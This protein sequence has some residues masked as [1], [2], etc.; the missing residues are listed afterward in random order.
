[1]IKEN[2][3]KLEKLLKKVSNALELEICSLK[4]QT[5]HNP[6]VLEIIIKKTSGDDISLNDCALFNQP[7]SDAIEKQIS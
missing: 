4:I 5:N 7:A 1:M 6:I 2:K 3:N